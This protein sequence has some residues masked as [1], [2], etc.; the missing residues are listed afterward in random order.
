[1][2]YNH[3]KGEI[4]PTLYTVFNNTLVLPVCYKMIGLNIYL[5]PL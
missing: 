5:L 3:A 1:M 4:F 2:S